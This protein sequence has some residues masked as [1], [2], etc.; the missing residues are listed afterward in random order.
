MVNT[1]E[2]QRLTGEQKPESLSLDSVMIVENMM[3]EEKYLDNVHKS[4][5]NEHMKH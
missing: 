5:H 1:V 2:I 4:E 3:D